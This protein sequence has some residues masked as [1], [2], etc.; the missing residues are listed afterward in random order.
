MNYGQPSYGEDHPVLK[1]KCVNHVV[2]HLSTSLWKL[3]K[4]STELKE[5]EGRV[6]GLGR[7][8]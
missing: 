8:L 5:G 6:E 3:K 2:K 7:N 1:E 4:V